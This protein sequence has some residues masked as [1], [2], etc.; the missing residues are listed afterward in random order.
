M[1]NSATQLHSSQFRW[2][3]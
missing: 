1:A 2:I 3:T